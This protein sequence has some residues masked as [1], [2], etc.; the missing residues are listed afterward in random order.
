MV[1]SEIAYFYS[2]VFLDGFLINS[3]ILMFYPSGTVND[4]YSNEWL[5]VNLG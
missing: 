5:F 1:D 3:L 4:D 2:K